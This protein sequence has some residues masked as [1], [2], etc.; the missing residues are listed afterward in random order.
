MSDAPHPLDEASR[1]ALLAS[2][3]ILDTPPDPNFD[4]VVHFAAERFH[5]PVALVSLTDTDR[6]WVKAAIGFEPKQVRRADAFSPHAIL[7]PDEVMVIEDATQ[8]PRF[9]DN[10]LVRNAPHIRFYAGAPIRAPN[11]QPLGTVSIA[12]VTPRRMDAAARRFLANMAMHT[13]L[14]LELHRKTVLLEDAATLDP[15][16]GLFNR[17]RFESALNAATED[18]LAGRPCA[19]LCLDLDHFKQI[20]DTYGHDVGDDLLREVG[21]RLT[22]LA[23]ANDVVARV[24]GDEFAILMTGP[25]DINSAVALAAR[26]V[27]AFAKPYAVGRFSAAIQTSIGVALCPIHGIGPAGLRRAADQAMYAAKQSG[28]GRIATAS[29][30]VGSGIAPISP[31][32]PAARL[33]ADLERAVS[34]G[35]LSLHWQPYLDVR[36]S[37]V[38]GYEALVR[39][40]RPGH[41]PV[42]PSLFVAIAEMSGLIAE[43]DRWVLGQACQEAAAWVGRERLSVNISGYWFGRGDLLELVASTLSRSGV[44]PDRLTLE[45]TERTLIEHSDSLRARIDAL[46]AMHVQV[47]LDD[48]GTGYSSLSYLQE[49][50]F[51]TLKL[52]RGFVSALHGD[53]RAEAVARAVLQLG[54]NLGITVC[55]EGVETQA[56]FDFLEAEGCDLVQGYFL[57][58]RSQSEAVRA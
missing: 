40:N 9:A 12:D 34:T 14:L 32:G 48:F 51:D 25:V 5:V 29:G 13:T 2:Y 18:A 45:L 39:W 31:D 57:D 55:A 11:G 50:P 21:R 22:R 53:G 23:R 17:H 49:F 20:N 52:D 44:A 54:A 30:H 58:D 43:L 7:R 41:G 46:H 47:A 3:R 1:I 37:E 10:I 4:T 28:G 19:L 27:Q 35:A 6:Q 24:G 8:D 42:E 16:T 15:L 33:V 26:I 36:R 56:Q 38:V